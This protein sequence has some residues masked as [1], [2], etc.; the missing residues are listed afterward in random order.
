MSNIHRS[1]ATTASVWLVAEWGLNDGKAGCHQ[2]RHVPAVDGIWWLHNVSHFPCRRPN[3]DLGTRNEWKREEKVDSCLSFK[4]FKCHKTYKNFGQ[5]RNTFSVFGS[6]ESE[7]I[8][9]KH[10]AVDQNLLRV[11]M[12]YVSIWKLKTLFDTAGKIRRKSPWFA[13]FDD[14]IM[15]KHNCCASNSTEKQK[16]KTSEI[17]RT[18][19]S[20]VSHFP[21]RRPNE[22]LGTRN[23]WKREEKVD[24]CLSFKQFK[25]HKTYKN[26][27]QMR[28]TFSVFGSKESELIL[29]KHSAVDQNLLRVTMC[30][31][32]IWNLIKLVA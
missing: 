25:C 5:M 1:M 31:V 9:V 10:S 4:Q 24:S 22:D 23:E 8:L 14:K 6:K 16:K 19:R 3:E 28:N 21:Y 32:S 29:V 20:N 26:F 30:Y 12:C 2:R 13:V 11:T 17:S 27:G 18:L 15:V 7:L